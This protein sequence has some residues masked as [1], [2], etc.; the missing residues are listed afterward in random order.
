MT[1][2]EDVKAKVIVLL[3]D[4]RPHLESSLDRLLDSGIIDFESEEPD[5]CLPKDIML[6]L[7]REI[8]FQYKAPNPTK[9][10]K[11]RIEKYFSV[12]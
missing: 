2:K 5:F 9:K 11:K 10:D 1:T 8:E 7:A 12:I 4:I 3:N 6:A